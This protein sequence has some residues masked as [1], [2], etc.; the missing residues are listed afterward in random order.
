MALAGRGCCRRSP[1]SRSE[2]SPTNRAFPSWAIGPIRADLPQRHS[3]SIAAG[4]RPD[5]GLRTGAP[6]RPTVAD[7]AAGFMCGALRAAA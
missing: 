4:A 7:M 5:P 6:I 2:A 1:C 3:A